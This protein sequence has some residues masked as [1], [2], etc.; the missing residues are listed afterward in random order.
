VQ[1]CTKAA[2][3]TFVNAQATTVGEIHGIVFDIGRPRKAHPYGS[4]LKGLPSDSFAAWCWRRTGPKSYGG[5]VVGPN[6]EVVDTGQGSNGGG[7]P[8]PGPLAIS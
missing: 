2:H 8:G 3:G 5:Y 1:A 7:P 6:G 4:I